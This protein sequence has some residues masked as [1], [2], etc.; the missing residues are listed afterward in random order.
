MRSM[1]EGHHPIVFHSRGEC[2]S[3]SLRL[4]PLP[5]PGRNIKENQS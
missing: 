2:P 1:V 4:V 5:V 3:T